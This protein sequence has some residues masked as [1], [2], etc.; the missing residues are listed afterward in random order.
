MAGFRQYCM[1]PAEPET[2]IDD[3]KSEREVPAI[4]DRYPKYHPLLGF[5]EIE[6]SL[7]RLAAV[8]VG[9]VHSRAKPRKV[10]LQVL[11]N[12]KSTIADWAPCC[13]VGTRNPVMD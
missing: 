3:E 13:H 4:V 2:K 6:K 10:F 7:A 11:N 12:M 5:A 1:T 8:A 9:V